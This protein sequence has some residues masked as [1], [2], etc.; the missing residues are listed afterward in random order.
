[1]VRGPQFEKRC[2]KVFLCSIFYDTF[3]KVGGTRWRSWFRHCGTNRKVAG[4]IPDCDIGIFHWRITSHSGPGVDS[5]CNRYEYQEYF[6]GVKAAGALDWQ[7]CH[8]HEPIVLKSGSLNL[9]EPSGP[10]KACNGIA[11]PWIRCGKRRMYEWRLTNWEWGL[12]KRSRSIKN[13]ISAFAWDYGQVVCIVIRVWAGLPRV[14]IPAGSTYFSVL[15][16]PLAPALLCSGL[17]A[18]VYNDQGV[19][20]T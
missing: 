1:V 7:S 6:L 16:H 3:K 8:L 9:L 5:A 17:L 4:L 19:T 14:R 20:L 2:P 18:L 10:V 12:R 13:I 15:Y 11:L